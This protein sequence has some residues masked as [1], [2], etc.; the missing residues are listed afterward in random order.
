MLGLNKTKI[1]SKRLTKIR[2]KRA[3]QLLVGLFLFFLFLVKDIEKREV[4]WG[5]ENSANENKIEDLKDEID[6]M[7]EVE[8]NISNQIESINHNIIV[9]ESQLKKTQEVANQ[10][11]QELE[12]LKQEIA[13][14]E[15]KISKQKNVLADAI[16]K[17]NAVTNE[18]QLIFMEKKGGVEKFFRTIDTY[19]EFEKNI[20]EIVE[21]IKETK[22]E[23]EKKK[24]EVSE[25][26]EE[27]SRIL[28]MQKDQQLALAYEQKRKQELLSKT[29]QEISS[30]KAQ[31]NALQSLGSPIS[32][33]E[34]IEAAQYA[35]K[36]TGVRTAFLLGVLR[37]ESNL[38]QNVGGGRYKTDMNPNQHFIFKEICKELGLNPSN[39]PVSKRIC[40]N[41]KSKDGC[42]GWGGA[43]GPAQFMP[44]T[45]MGYKDK[46]A[47]IT[48]NNPPNPWNLKD[49]LVAMGLK[50][51]D[52]PG[53]KEGKRLAEKKAASMYLAG[54]NWQ[55]YVWYGDRV[56]YYADG[57]EKYMSGKD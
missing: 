28:E 1:N 53:V 11:N 21:K 13:K 26:L 46:V 50:L 31:L 37:V 38:G 47:R 56:I 57:F 18:M 43:M 14:V 54:G 35:S 33:E 17:M 36:K 27:T 49:A 55:Y 7:E 8:M 48:G 20:L 51:G 39:M 9:I 45:W 34:A 2:K 19:D 30:L 4:V 32:L 40:Y 29:R 10:L 24:E 41:T 23:V 22:K 6:E 15:E 16:V 44:S 12:R 52:V 42:G 3:I 25:K 5:A